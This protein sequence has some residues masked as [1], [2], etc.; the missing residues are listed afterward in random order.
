LIERAYAIAPEDHDIAY[1]LAGLY[2][3]DARYSSTAAQVSSM[4][5]KSLRV[6]E[7]ALKDAH[8]PR[9]RFND[10]PG[11]TQAAFEAGEYERAA[12]YSKEALSLAVQPDFISNN[13]DAIHYGKHRAR[14]DGPKAGRRRGCFSVSSESRRDKG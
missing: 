6:F 9:E 14:K 13:A 4:A 5:A 12:A 8:N 1:E 10:L 11:A 3:R 2:W 7:Q